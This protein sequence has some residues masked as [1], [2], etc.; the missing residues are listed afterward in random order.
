MPRLSF[1]TSVVDI[2]QPARM[3]VR[4]LGE[5][6]A[7]MVAAVLRDIEMGPALP[8][9][10]HLLVLVGE[11]HVATQRVAIVLK[12]Q[13]ADRLDGTLIDI[14]FRDTILGEGS[15]RDI[16]R[17]FLDVV[18][19]FIRHEFRE[20]V[21]FRGQLFDDPHANDFTLTLQTLVRNET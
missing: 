6:H 3:S 15:E 20:A 10:H 21:F 11:D 7:P 9:R 16:A 5:V 14:T 18:E 12:T 2:R 17:A 4:C 8:L 1:N 19:R 13:V